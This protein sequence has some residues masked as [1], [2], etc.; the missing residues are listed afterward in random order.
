MADK[1]TIMVTGVAGYWGSRVAR[2]L[3]VEPGVHVVGVDRAPAE[4]VELEGPDYI[5]ADLG[6]PLLAELLQV[7]QVE[8][9]CHLAFE[10][11]AR[12]SE[13]SFETNVMGAMKLLGAC[14]ESGVRRVVLK[15]STMVYG[16]AADNSAFLLED[17]PLRGGRRTGYNRH[18]CE[19]ESFVNGFRRQAPEME[20]AILR[21]ANIVGPTAR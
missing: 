11:T 12:P 3:L 20:I 7:E 4:E 17:A 14:A 15:S 21:F 16:A 8:T 1:T 9:V 13:K 5:Q 19:I 2:G 18:R 6:N 10:E